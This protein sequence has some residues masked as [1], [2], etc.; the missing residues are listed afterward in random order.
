MTDTG[1]PT[2]SKIIEV[3]AEG[4]CCADGCTFKSLAGKCCANEYR[5]EGWADGV[6]VGS[7]QHMDRM[8][9]R[10]LMG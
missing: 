8:L 2:S 10:A 6:A 1:S 9:E 5:A 7:R 3:M 4:I